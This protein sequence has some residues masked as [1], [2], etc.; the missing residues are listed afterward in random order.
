MATMR[1]LKT[2]IGTGQQEFRAQSR[3]QEQVACDSREAQTIKKTDTPGYL[4]LTE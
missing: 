1:T 4:I 2:R 3:N